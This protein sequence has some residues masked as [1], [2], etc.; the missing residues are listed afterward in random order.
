M[1]GRSDNR[2][3][4]EDVERTYDILGFRRD[5]RAVVPPTSVELAAIL[6]PARLKQLYTKAHEQ[7][8]QRQRHG[9]LTGLTEYRVGVVMAAHRSM[10]D[11]TDVKRGLPNYAGREV[12]QRST[13]IGTIHT[14]PWDVSQSTGDVRS[15]I[16][17]NDLLGGVVTCTGRVFFLVKDPVKPTKNQSLFK[18]EIQLQRISLS[19]TSSIF[20]SRGMI[21]VLSASFDLPIHSTRDPLLRAVCERLGLIYYAGDMRSLTVHKQ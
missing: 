10:F 12:T 9:M 2:I 20:K 5:G 3:T 13:I 11:L 6:N 19:E 21:G 18:Q 8:Q 15:L 7:Y 16:Y 1:F 14:H 4:R 17:T